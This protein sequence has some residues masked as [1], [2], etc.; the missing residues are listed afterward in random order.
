LEQ[1][2]E[3]EMKRL[4]ST[5]LGRFGTTKEI[6][7][8]HGLLVSIA[9]T[10]ICLP[11]MA[12][13]GRAA[14]SGDNPWP[15]LEA[16]LARDRVPAGSA[17]ARLIAENQ[18][19]QL[20]R[21]AEAHDKMGLPPWLRV[22]WRK[23]HPDGVFLA[24]DPMGGYP[25]ILKELHE[26]MVLHPD[27]QPGETA[28][29][30]DSFAEKGVVVGPDHRL[31]EEDLATRAESDIRVNYWDPSLIVSSSNNLFK[32]Q[33]SMYY[34]S[35]Q[36]ATWG[37]TLLPLGNDTFQS[38]PAVDWTSDGT[39]W[40]TFI[41]VAVDGN[42]VTLRLRS[43]RSSD[44]GASWT[45]DADVSGGQT[46]S[47]K[48]M[49]WTDHSQSSP[50]KDHVYDIWHNGQAVFMNRHTGP[51]A[52]GAWGSPI[53]VSGSETKG[54]GI[55]ADVKTNSAGQV[56]AFWP[57]TG[58]RKI[59]LVRS[60]DGGTT[61]SKPI[62]VASLFDEFDI[63]IPAQAQRAALVYVTAGAFLNGRKSDVYAAWTDLNGTKGCNTP[64]NDPN[65]NVTSLCKSRIW[66]AKSTN[67]GL[68]W[69]RPVMLNNPPT[70]NDQ[71]NPWM[72]VDETTGGLGIIFYDTAGEDRTF[73]NVWYMSSF[74]EG[75]TWSAPVKL[76]SQS[77][78]ATDLAGGA[79]QFGDYNSMSGIAG[80]FFP[81]WSDR[82]EGLISQIWTVQIN[83]TKSLT[84]SAAD[85][86]RWFVDAV[87]ISSCTQ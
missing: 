22:L 71:F 13:A 19:L 35:D 87:S 43:M 55:G 18:D 9:L 41:G 53:Q 85:Q 29:A 1:L 83:N 73:V 34:S 81:T 75:S 5:R 65:T 40:T 44:G 60:L 7:M 66:F 72:V 32:G 11:A 54:T 42:N 33:M 50:F 39:A 45:P 61:Y 27:L 24:G 80:T 31:S 36:G 69:S 16:Q 67:G 15:S 58:S 30:A 3:G 47:D 62:T 2:I 46:E 82:R 10:L 25:L 84:C 57:D 26:W 21:P 4:V 56:F 6:D 78:S 52:G 12:A 86:D 51:G 68:K 76:T 49:M 8:R 37:S 79:F 17:L 48:E 28:V 74:T 38:D 77:S 23:Q 64:F 63:A 59:Y 20:L 14:T 70:L